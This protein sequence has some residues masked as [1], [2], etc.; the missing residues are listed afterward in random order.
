M[1]T[2]MRTERSLSPPAEGKLVRG[3][4]AVDVGDKITVRLLA[5]D[6]E[7]GFLY[8]ALV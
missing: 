2:E 6:T 4:G 1:A 5:T 3:E 7:K 8:F